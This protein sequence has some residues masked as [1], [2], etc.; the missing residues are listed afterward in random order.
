MESINNVA[1]NNAQIPTENDE[2]MTVI[3]KR[4]KNPF[5][6][7]NMKTAYAN[8]GGKDKNGGSGL[9]I[10]TTHLYVKFLPQDSTEVE[11]LEQLEI[12]DSLNLFDYPLDVDIVSSGTF[13][14]DPNVP[15]RHP[16]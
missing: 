2:G 10:R 12:T 6:V 14:H 15:V 8:I 7:A 11:T 9:N 4:K 5:T 3:G 13:Y 16:V 1:N